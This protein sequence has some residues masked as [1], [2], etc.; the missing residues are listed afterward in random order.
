MDGG[1]SAITVTRLIKT[2]HHEAFLALIRTC[3]FDLKYFKLII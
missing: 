2:M 1:I 3:Q